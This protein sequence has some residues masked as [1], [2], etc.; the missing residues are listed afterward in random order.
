MLSISALMKRALKPHALAHWTRPGV[1]LLTQVLFEVDPMGL[2][3][4]GVPTDEYEPEAELAFAL[5]LGCETVADLWKVEYT[6]DTSEG[7]SD[8]ELMT[9][10]NKSFVSLFSEEVYLDSRL[11]WT[12]REALELCTEAHISQGDSETSPIVMQ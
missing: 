5:S 3:S 12:F 1:V 8:E 11:S 7:T 9:H 6:S 10:L 2:R 4:F